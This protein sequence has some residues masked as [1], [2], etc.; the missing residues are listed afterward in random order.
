MEVYDFLEP[1]RVSNQADHLFL[2]LELL[3]DFADICA[4]LT[5]ALGSVLRP[6]VLDQR[7]HEEVVPLFAAVFKEDAEEVELDIWAKALD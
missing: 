2:A 6:Q 1:G 3:T 7:L 5:G 4:E